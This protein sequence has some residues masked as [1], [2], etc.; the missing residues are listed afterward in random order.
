M[1]SVKWNEILRKIESDDEINFIAEAITPVHALGIEALLIHLNRIG[2]RTKGFI[3]AVPHYETGMTLTEEMFHREC[4]K[5]IT[6]AQ[7]DSS[8]LQQ[9]NNPWFY[10]GLKNSEGF[11]RVFYYA[12]PFIPSFARIPQ[13]MN[14]RK[15]DNLMV[16]IT[17]EGAANYLDNPYKPSKSWTFGMNLKSKLWFL[18]Q[19]C[20]RDR[21]FAYK[22]RKTGKLQNY[23]MYKSVG[24]K[25]EPNDEYVA[26]VV[27]LYES[28]NDNEDYSE[29]EDAII[30]APSLLYQSGV[31]SRRADV[32]LFE[33]IKGELGSGFKYV[34]KPHPREKELQD[35]NR[36]NCYVERTNQQ[37]LE[38]ILAH[39][40]LK[41]RCVI[42]DTG[43][44]LV[45]IA[46][47]Y[48]IKVIAI[49]KL[50]NKSDLLVEN[51]FDDYNRTY[52]NLIFIPGS[53]QELKDFLSTL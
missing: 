18:T 34:V 37:S 42:G 5:G 45:N 53:W 38:R 31:M 2:V 41:P 15:N 29:Y 51:Y 3:L 21:Y 35:Y 9:G 10:F 39:V 30:F 16:Y 25:W 8:E 33:E 32:E 44:A 50:I 23:W 20:L 11:E 43:T 24:D 13:V 48:D 7:I 40:D 22:L 46:A 6:V 14:I 12:T 47:L 1:I 4:Y 28:E 27:K 36:L 49:A 17:D 26:D 52:D 19:R